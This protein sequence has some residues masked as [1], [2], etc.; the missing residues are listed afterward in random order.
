[1]G[2]W[3]APFTTE[4]MEALRVLML[5]PI[6][7]HTSTDVL[8]NFVGDDDLFD[9]LDGMNG[10]DDCR[11]TVLCFLQEWFG[12]CGDSAEIREGW[13]WS[14]DFE[15]GAL[16][17]V[18]KMLTDWNDEQCFP[19]NLTYDGDTVMTPH[20]LATYMAERLEKIAENHPFIMRKI[21]TQTFPDTPIKV[22]KNGTYEVKLNHKG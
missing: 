15:D 16:D 18:K 12:K 8:Y 11:P 13:G 7:A 4:K 2:C 9:R 1:M 20:D 19:E 5:K 14:N 6:P 3:N 10:N 17:I 22:K 21:F